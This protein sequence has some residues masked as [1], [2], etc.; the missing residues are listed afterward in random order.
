MSYPLN[1][2]LPDPLVGFAVANTEDEHIALTAFGYGPAYVEPTHADDPQT[3]E[4]QTQRESLLAQA[5]AV[6]LTVD[7]RWSDKRLAAEIAKLG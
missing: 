3:P 5:A 6:G 4:E 7:G 1:M 2:Q